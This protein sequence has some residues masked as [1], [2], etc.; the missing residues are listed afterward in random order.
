MAVSDG[1]EINSI[2]GLGLVPSVFNEKNI[3]QL[4][5]YIAVGHTRYS[6]TGGNTFNNV[7]PIIIKF[8]DDFMALAHNGNLVNVPELM[9]LIDKRKLQSTS[10][11]EVMAYVIERM[12]GKSWEEKIKNAMPFLKG[13]F[14]VVAVT[15]KKLL[16]FRDPKGFRPL[17]IGRMN[18]DFIFS[19]ETCALDTIGADYIR[20]V[21]PGEIISVDEHGMRSIQTKASQMS[22]CLFEYIYLARPD[23][24]FNKELVH[25]VRQRSGEILSYEA[26]VPADLV[27]AVP[28]SG[29]S[30]AIGFSKASGIPFGEILIKNRYIGRTFIQPEQHMRELGVKIKFNPL[31]K[32]VKGKRIIIVDDSLVRGT[33]MK[34]IIQVLR[35]CGAKK[36][37]IRICSPPIPFSC[38]FGVDTP[39]RKQLIASEK[40]VDQIKEFIGADSL[41][42]LSLSGMVQASHQ[43]K[44]SLCTACFTGTYPVPIDTNFTK[45]MLEK[46]K[47]LAV[48]ISN[49]GTG[50]N[51][52]AIIDAI[53]N[54]SLKAK[55]AV[56]VSDQKDALGLKR[57]KKRNIP[58]HILEKNED[59][60]TLLKKTYPCDYIVLGGWKQ[61]IPDEMIAKFPDKIVNIHPGLIPDT[62][63]GVVKNPDNT[64]GLW[65]R[66]KF[67]NKAINNF[68][69]NKA[70]YAGS[71]VHFLSKEVDFGKVLGR[72]YEK[73]HKDDTIES[74]YGRLKQQEHTI[75]ITSLMRLCNET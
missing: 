25:Q 18:G 8:K 12:R 64:L 69:E 59:L 39:N 28:D 63:D 73:I 48:L 6:T 5:G 2:K 38:Y 60:I 22:F 62:L 47:K 9:K 20:D 4:K 46:E 1:K 42:Y 15:K 65:N 66:K 16:A 10:D 57:A 35:Q 36:I 75:L 29:T 37:H 27:V 58:T 49:A 14:S 54:R 24:V 72:G 13:A 26:H 17:V 67:T 21:K 41:A 51:L 74:L 19:S 31:K 56:V 32:I 44:N 30:A 53:D 23:S 68:L 7:Q 61:M 45:D 3:T 43:K 52:Q 33:T 34:K 50:T 11:T 55:I 71:S 40:S 70:T